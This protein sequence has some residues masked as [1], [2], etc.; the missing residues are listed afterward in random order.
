MGFLDAIK[1]AA[2]ALLGT[3]SS[4][5]ADDYLEHIKSIPTLKS[6]T[7]EVIDQ[8]EEDDFGVLIYNHVFALAEAD[9]NE[10]FNRNLTKLNEPRKTAY[11]LS[12]VCDQFVT[13]ID[14]I[15]AE[16]FSL[17]PDFPRTME[18]VN[19]PSLKRYYEQVIDFISTNYNG[20]LPFDNNPENDFESTPEYQSFSKAMAPFNKA[21]QDI[22][23]AENID[24][25]QIFV[26]YVKENKHR[27]A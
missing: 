2:M 11:I 25:Y 23:E 9:S 3:G 5:T 8:T 21:F 1:K 6:L 22:L 14:E 15:V 20:Q 7:P 13:D 24:N 16:H 18:I 19:C 10:A 4:Y 12:T 17:L 26:R 27:F